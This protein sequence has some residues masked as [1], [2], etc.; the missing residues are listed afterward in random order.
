MKFE[1]EEVSLR[2]VSLWRV[3][4]VTSSRLSLGLGGKVCTLALKTVSYN[5]YLI[6]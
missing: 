6:E 5:E 3:V 2:K 4:F 1:S